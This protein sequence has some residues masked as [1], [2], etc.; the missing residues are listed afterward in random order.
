VFLNGVLGTD[1]KHVCVSRPRRVGKSVDADMLVAY[2][3]RG[4]DSRAQF[5]GLDVSRDPSFE[6]HLNAHDVIRVDAQRMILR[7]EGGI[8]GLPETIAREVIPELRA[9]WPDAVPEG[10]ADL[11]RALELASAA[12]GSGF[13]FVID[14]WDCPMRL[15][16]DDDEAQRRYLDFL[17]DL[18]KGAPYV[19]VA[20]MTGILPIRKYGVHS[21]LNM[22]DEFSMTR[23][24]ALASLMGFNACDVEGLCAR[25]GM[26]FGEMARWYDGYLLRMPPRREPGGAPIGPDSLGELMHVY[27]PNSV[28]RAIANGACSGYWTQ[29]ETYE[30]LQRY[31]DIDFDGVAADLVAM[32]DG[33]R[34]E[35]NVERFANTMRDFASKDDMYAL[36]VHLGYLGYDSAAG[37]VFIP[38]EELRREFASTV[39]VGARPGLARLARESRQLIRATVD[40]DAEYVADALRRAHSWAAGP[41]YYNDEQALRA[42]VKFAY[43]AAMDD[44]LRIDE[45]PSG[46]GYC[47]L[48]FVPKPGSALPP[49]LVELKWDKPVSAA[50]AQARRRGYPAALA[51]LGG[52]CV[53]VGATYDEATCEH[54]CEIERV[55]LA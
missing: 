12:K 43:I 27:N 28:A 26:D 36:L 49:M 30:A 42:A 38:N 7:G 10:S 41:R 15:A 22:F 47:D 4:A 6:R 23:P 18:F 34:V 33:Q 24:M 32:L 31:I 3:T 48:A 50:L 8:P 1:A 54:R 46:R 40:G 11:P 5:A 55:Q 21:A 13:V 51:G 17:R 9:E 16:E 20:Y 45:L 39:E 37:S 2:Y 29:T 25:F 44:Y 19:E 35:A 53:L 14:E 52:E